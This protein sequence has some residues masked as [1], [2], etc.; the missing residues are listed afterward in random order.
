MANTRCNTHM[1]KKELP[2]V[3]VMLNIDLV[4]GMILTAVDSNKNMNEWIHNKWL[5]P[6]GLYIIYD[7]FFN[8]LRRSDPY[9]RQ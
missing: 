5:S 8:S 7:L 9:M 3:A 4:T 2:L 1:T 6:V